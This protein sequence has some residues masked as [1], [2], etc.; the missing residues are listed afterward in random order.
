VVG[1]AVFGATANHPLESVRVSVD[2]S[3]QQRAIFEVNCILNI[4]RRKKAHDLSS[5]VAAQS[6][7][8]LE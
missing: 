1:R 6:D 4:T 8:V 3:R 2:E 5:S 7:I